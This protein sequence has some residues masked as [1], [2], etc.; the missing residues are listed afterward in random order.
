VARVVA[1]VEAPWTVRFQPGRGA[2]E[3]IT[4]SALQ[5]WSEHTEP[6]VK[7]FSGTAAYSRS[8]EAPAE[9]FAQGT[10]LW[11]D[12]GDVKNLAEVTVNG[13]PIGTAWKKPFRVEA[14]GALRVGIN[15][16]E[17]KVTNLW[18]NRMIGDRQ[19]GAPKQYTFTV[20]VFYK[21]DSPLLPSGLLGPLQIVQTTPGPTAGASR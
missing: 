10:R 3:S 19:P 6:G 9:W 15:Q 2:P 8:L 1:T 16:L 21:A 20:P 11:I 13:T 18:V 17:V 5:S 14:T 7:Y 12:L 4:L